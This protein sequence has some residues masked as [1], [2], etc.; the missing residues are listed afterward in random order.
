MTDL[1][2]NAGDVICLRSEKDFKMTVV[3]FAPHTPSVVT[4]MYLNKVTFKLETVLLPV[5]AVE[6]F[7]PVEP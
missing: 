6:P 3:N 5:T 1:F 2:F 4:A 7:V